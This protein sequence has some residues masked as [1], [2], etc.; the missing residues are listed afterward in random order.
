MIAI[1]KLRLGTRWPLRQDPD[2]ARLFILKR[3]P[4]IGHLIDSPSHWLYLA[5][6]TNQ[7]GV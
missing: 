2:N 6:A 1:E 4:A 3:D 5:I 7:S